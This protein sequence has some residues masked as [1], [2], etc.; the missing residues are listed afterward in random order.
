[1]GRTRKVVAMSK[2]N[3]SNKEKTARARGEKALKL[4][5]DELRAPDWLSDEGAI[6]FERI[7]QNA[8]EIELLDNLD[9]GFVAVYADNYARYTKAATALNLHGPLEQTERGHKTLSSWMRVLNI[10]A[11]NMAM[12]STKLGLAATDRLKLIVPVIKDDGKVN[13]FIKY[14][15]G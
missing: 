9:L 2:R 14:L 15:N 4:P 6:E 1:M 13:K 11:Q 12:C 8:K 5:R 10:C 3:I 7:V